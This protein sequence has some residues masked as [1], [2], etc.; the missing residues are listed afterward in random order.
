MELLH[1][2]AGEAS[3][4]RAALAAR[5]TSAVP[6]PDVVCLHGVPTGF[7]WRQACADLARRCGLVVVGGGRPAGGVLVLS[8][9]GVDVLAVEEL[10]FARDAGAVLASLRHREDEFVLAAAHLT[11]PTQ[12][13]R[14]T[15]AA[16]AFA[17]GVTTVRYSVSGL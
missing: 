7:R 10:P 5:V 11:E 15:A 14:L 6:S 12:R 13:D 4:D 2:D 1:V 17:P 3:G 9:L 8:T 16:Q